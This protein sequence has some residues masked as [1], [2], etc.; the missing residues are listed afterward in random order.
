MNI[1][2]RNAVCMF[3]FR[4]CVASCFIHFRDGVL[5]FFNLFATF[6]LLVLPLHVDIYL[7]ISAPRLIKPRLRELS[8]N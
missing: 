5:I 7:A 3:F 4:K 2:T 8:Y 1:L 6:P